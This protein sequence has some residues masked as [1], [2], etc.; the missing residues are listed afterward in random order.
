MEKVI[1]NHRL[2]E[3][4]YKVELRFKVTKDLRAIVNRAKALDKE[5]VIVG[6]HLVLLVDGNKRTYFTD[7]GYELGNSEKI[8]NLEDKN[9]DVQG[10]FEGCEFTLLD[11]TNVDTSN[12]VDM[13]SLFY[14]AVIDNIIFGE[15]NTHN[16]VDMTAMF[17]F[18]TIRCGLDLDFLDT[19]NVENTQ[20][21]FEWI[22]APFLKV[23]KFNM[24]KCKNINAMFA[25]CTTD[26]VDIS[27]YDLSNVEDFSMLFD[28]NKIGKIRIGYLDT[29]NAVN[30]EA[31]FRGCKDLDADLIN[32]L[33]VSNVTN[34]GAMLADSEIHGIIDL[35]SWNTNKLKDISL[36]FNN[37]V[38]DKIEMFK[39]RGEVDMH[40]AFDSCIIHSDKLDLSEFRCTGDTRLIF[41][42]LWVDTLILNKEFKESIGNFGKAKQMIVSR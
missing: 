8:F 15:F 36:M 23:S 42:N 18:S 30:M 4:L 28:T 13:N 39:L 32:K 3:G 34:V 31:M 27:Q 24:S 2:V 14:L 26:E 6:K 19:S 38:I 21:M 10:V 9:N 12:T 5:V 35:R 33:D 7:T 40:D 17:L 16:V 41:R 1:I 25:H 37:A 20:S 22:T 29:H 11:L